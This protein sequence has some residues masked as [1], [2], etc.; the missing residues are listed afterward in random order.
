MNKM[1][2][3]CFLPYFVNE[4]HGFHGFLYHY[5]LMN[6]MNRTAGAMQCLVKSGASGVF[7]RQRISRISRIFDYSRHLTHFNLCNL[8]N[9]LTFYCYR[10]RFRYRFRC[11]YRFRFRFFSRRPSRNSNPVPRLAVVGVVLLAILTDCQ[12]PA[13]KNTLDYDMCSRRWS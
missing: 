5:H 10:F 4:F 12:Q 11:H 2:F 13:N 9:L 3:Y 8:C 1:H 6:L 7:Y